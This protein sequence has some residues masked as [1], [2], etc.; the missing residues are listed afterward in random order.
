METN[1]PSAET[2]KK[3]PLRWQSGRWYDDARGDEYQLPIRTLW[4]EGH[5]L[6]VSMNASQASGD[7]NKLAPVIPAVSG[8]A[9]VDKR[10]QSASAICLMGDDKQHT[11]MLPLS[12]RQL[13]EAAA[14]A[15]MV[16]RE[17]GRRSEA[18]DDD[19]SYESVLTRAVAS[20]PIPTAYLGFVEADWEIGSHDNWYVEVYV[21]EEIF[22]ALVEAIRADRAHHLYIGLKFANLYVTDFHAPP[23]VGVR[24]YLPPSPNSSRYDSA[25]G[26]VTRI[27]WRENAGPPE[28]ADRREDA[29]PK[30]D[31]P[32]QKDQSVQSDLVVANAHREAAKVTAMLAIG[33]SLK[34]LVA[35][36][37]L[38][39]ILLVFR[40]R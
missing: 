22:S 32:D 19:Q 15:A 11:R 23:A 7:Q 28:K 34:W 27:G 16:S 40:F 25:K 21:G 20:Y 30:L 12:I 33:R 2:A 5:D 4:I 36:T 39:F 24:W 18:V 37:I 31:L 6:V 35:F 10:D 14:T 13:P 17:E 26:I 9:V 38:V 3:M 29:P 1:G 8:R